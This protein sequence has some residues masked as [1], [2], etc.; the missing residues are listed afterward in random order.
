MKPAGARLFERPPT[1]V[2]LTPLGAA[3]V[4]LARGLLSEIETAEEKIEAG[5]DPEDRWSPVD[6]IHPNS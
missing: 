4:E 2:R 5:A 1:E 6:G 3:A